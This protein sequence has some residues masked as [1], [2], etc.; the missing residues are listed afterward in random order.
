MAAKSTKTARNVAHDLIGDDKPSRKAKAKKSAVKK[1]ARNQYDDD[2]KIKIVKEREVR[3]GT[4][5]AKMWEMVKKAKT[6]GQLRQMR[7]R[8]RMGDDLGGFFGGFV[9][10]RNIRV[11]A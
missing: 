5:A 10:D 7:K 11:G 4:T 6:V 3:E 1:V 2:A 9:R 8:A